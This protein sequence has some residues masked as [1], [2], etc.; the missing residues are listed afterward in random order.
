MK[1]EIAEQVIGA[2]KGMDLAIDRL[3]AAVRGIEDESERKRMFKFI[4][5][6]IHDLHVQITLPVVKYH[7]DLHPDLPR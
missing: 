2:M 3:D 6:M 1:R 4:A 7:P 5:H